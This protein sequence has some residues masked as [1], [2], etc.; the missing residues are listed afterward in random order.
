M[1]SF[2][3]LQYLFRWVTRVHDLHCIYQLP[4]IYPLKGLLVR[5]QRRP[6]PI[7]I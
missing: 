6:R 5:Y 3:H 2:L 4:T 1:L 7:E